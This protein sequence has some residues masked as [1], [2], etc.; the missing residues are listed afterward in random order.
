MLLENA[1]QKIS[2]YNQLCLHYNLVA[3]AI[4]Q[5]LRQSRAPLSP[6]YEP[7]LVAALISFDMG[8]MMGEG[9][10]KRYDMTAN[11]FAARLHK[12]LREVEPIFVP[13]INV[14][15]SAGNMDELSS[16]IKDI[17]KKLAAG[18]QG[19]LHEQGNEFHVGA[20]KLLHFLNPEMFMIVDRNTSRAIRD[21][22]GVP[23]K[24]TTQPGYSEKYYVQ[25]LNAVKKMIVEYGTERFRSLEPG[26]PVMRVFDKIAFA[27][28]AFP[29]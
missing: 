11:G 18:G 13:L 17:Y 7:Y 23:Y 10:I 22:F 24:N 2:R 26:T 21:A 1:S 12:K 25:S 6:A 27:H 4:Y 20:T 29:M 8:R 28:S 19:G 3:N 16:T 9:I 5:E 15:I 14:D